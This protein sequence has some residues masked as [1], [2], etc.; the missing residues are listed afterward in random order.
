MR[1]DGSISLDVDHSRLLRRLEA[2][3]REAEPLARCLDRRRHPRA[4]RHHDKSRTCLRRQLSNALQEGALDIRCR[5]KLFT[6]LVPA[7]EL[8]LAQRNTQL[9]QPEG[10]ATRGFHQLLEHLGHDREPDLRFQELSCSRPIEVGQD[11]FLEA[12]RVDRRSRCQGRDDHRDSLGLESASGEEDRFARG[13][14]Q[15]LAVVHD[16]QHRLFLGCSC[17]EAQAGDGDHER[18]AL[19]R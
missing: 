8:P 15:P 6:E 19:D 13:D 10:V 3:G 2:C 16:R 18:I 7:A 5:G 17:E 1:K 4:G 12:R 11:E 9:T 14:V